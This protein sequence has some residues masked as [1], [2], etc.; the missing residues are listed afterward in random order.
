MGRLM[1]AIMSPLNLEDESTPKQVMDELALIAPHCRW[2][3]GTW[4]GLGI[5]WDA[6]QNTTRH[7]SELSSYLIRI[8]RQARVARG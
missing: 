1:D 6:V 3:D 2:T 5:A 7:I 4:D 8:Y